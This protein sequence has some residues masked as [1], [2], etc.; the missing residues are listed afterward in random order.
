MILPEK[1]IS[2]TKRGVRDKDVS[3]E[4]EKSDFQ[5]LQVRAG[6]PL[7]HPVSLFRSQMSRIVFSIIEKTSETEGGITFKSRCVSTAN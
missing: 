5:G 2:V 7:C 3:M 1:F 6:I 4:D